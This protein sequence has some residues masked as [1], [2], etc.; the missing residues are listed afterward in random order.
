MAEAKCLDSINNSTNTA[1]TT[2][3]QH[4]CHQH[5]TIHGPKLTCKNTWGWTPSRVSSSSKPSVRLISSTPFSQYG[6]SPF[7]S[8]HKSWDNTSKDNRSLSKLRRS[9]HFVNTKAQLLGARSTRIGRPLS[10]NTSKGVYA[11]CELHGACKC[12][13]TTQQPA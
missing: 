12:Y 5:C 7:V 11:A 10:E 6:T 13:V 1:H 8:W 4:R 2:Q 3:T 9:N